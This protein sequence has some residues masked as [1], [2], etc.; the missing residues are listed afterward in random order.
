[1]S[2]R[3]VVVAIRSVDGAAAVVGPAVAA[4]VAGAVVCWDVHPARRAPPARR[5]TSRDAAKN[6]ELLIIISP[7]P[8]SM[9]PV[10]RYYLLFDGVN[11]GRFST[12]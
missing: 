3:L 10:N 2:Y 12:W 9:L 1:V 6:P 5:S 7:F 8:D 11:P 4:V